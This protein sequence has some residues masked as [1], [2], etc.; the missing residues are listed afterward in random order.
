[1]NSAVFR[2]SS[3]LLRRRLLDRVLGF[4]PDCSDR[5]FGATIVQTSSKQL[6]PLRSPPIRRNYVVSRT[7]SSASEHLSEVLTREHAEEMEDEATTTMPLDLQELKEKLEQVWKIVDDGATTRLFRTV[8]AT[9]VQIGFHCQDT[10][11]VVDEEGSG[12]GDDGEEDEEAAPIR[13]TLTTTKAGKTLVLTCLSQDA[14]PIIHGAAVTSEDVENVQAK[15]GAVD[16]SQFQGPEFS[17]LAEDLQEAFL[18]YIQ[19]DVGVTEDVASFISMYADFREQQQ[20]VQF[21]E[22]TKRIL[23]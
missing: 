19:K 22:E 3:A 17:E 18:V 12:Y 10:V 7:L 20:Y 4:R 23:S 15:G 13:F 9:K 6:C 5:S 14:T 1:M 8:G 16:Y 2:S 11:E 21:L